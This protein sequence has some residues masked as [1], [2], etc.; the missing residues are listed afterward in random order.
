MLKD[1]DELKR[2]LSELS[3]I[4][5][6]FKSEAVQLRIVDHIFGLDSAEEEDVTDLSPATRKKRP[7]NAKPQ[8][9]KEHPPA[10]RVILMTT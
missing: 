3:K 5:N 6:E 7:T 2:Q 10:P 1:F 8:V 4:V 9:R